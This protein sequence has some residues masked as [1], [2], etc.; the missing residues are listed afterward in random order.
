MRILVTGGSGYIGSHTLVS[1]IREGYEVL[2]YD[3]LT[4]SSFEVIVRVEELTG[5]PIRFIRGDIQDIQRF[6]ALFS[7]EKI[8]AVIHFAALKS[9]GES[10]ANPFKYY[11]NYEPCSFFKKTVQ[12]F[13]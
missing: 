2:V 13:Y 7:E 6:G 1:L 12:P 3:N 11:Q 5:K 9:V 8:E 10:V 4:N